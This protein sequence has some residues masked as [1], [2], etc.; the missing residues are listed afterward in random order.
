MQ[1]ETTKSDYNHTI[2]SLLLGFLQNYNQITAF[3]EIISLHQ[4][5]L[6]III[7]LGE[8]CIYIEL[9]CVYF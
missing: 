2:R 1:F 3:T 7:I 9:T 6:D 5:S 4:P 8:I